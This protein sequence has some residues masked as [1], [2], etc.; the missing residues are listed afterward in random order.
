MFI[1]PGGSPARTSVPVLQTKGPDDEFSLFP[2]RF[3]PGQ[4]LTPFPI[5]YAI[6]LWANDH[7]GAWGPESKIPAF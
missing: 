1:P 2:A 6:L 3:F 4:P 7:R 5:V